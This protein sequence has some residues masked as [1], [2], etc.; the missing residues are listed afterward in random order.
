MTA[1]KVAK[2]SSLKLLISM[3]SSAVTAVKSVEDLAPS[4]L[5]RPLTPGLAATD[6]ISISSSL[7]PKILF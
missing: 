4:P 3:S 6:Y 1:M 5:P 7:L 2:M